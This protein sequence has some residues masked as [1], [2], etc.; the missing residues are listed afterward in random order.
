MN[1]GGKK[2]VLWGTTLDNLVS[3]E[4]IMPD[5]SWLKLKPSNI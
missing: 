5:G 2:A 1:A 3:W 4:M